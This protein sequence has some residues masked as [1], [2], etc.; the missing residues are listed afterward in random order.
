MRYVMYFWLSLYA[1]NFYSPNIPSNILV[2]MKYT[3]H[4][5]LTF[6]A[7]KFEISLEPRECIYGLEKNLSIFNTFTFRPTWKGLL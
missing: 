3:R 5:L 6:I 1:Y 4:N 7:Y 2:D